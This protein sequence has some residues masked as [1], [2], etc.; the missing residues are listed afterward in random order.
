MT[1]NELIKELQELVPSFG[2]E[3]VTVL[4]KPL[5]INPQEYM[6]L[7]LID[8]SQDTE[9]PQRGYVGFTGS[10]F[11]VVY[12]DGCIPTIGQLNEI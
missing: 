3:D 7:R 10:P 2:E 1:L 6:D 12:G 4:G 11:Y 8:F 5:R 9:A